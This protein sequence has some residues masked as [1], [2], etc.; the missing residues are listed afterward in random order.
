[1]TATGMRRGTSINQRV[2]NLQSKMMVRD[3]MYMTDPKRLRRV[4]YRGEG[5]A[6]AVGPHF[7]VREQPSVLAGEKAKRFNKMKLSPLKT[8]NA[9]EIINS[10]KTPRLGQAFKSVGRHQRDLSELR[11]LFF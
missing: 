9:F 2:H 5:E 7:G 10:G 6:R 8:F 4:R 3:E 11:D 1:M